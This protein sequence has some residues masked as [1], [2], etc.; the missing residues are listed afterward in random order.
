MKYDHSIGWYT[1]G[2]AKYHKDT[3]E[4][5]DGVDS[6]LAIL[7][8]RCLVNGIDSIVDFNSAGIPYIRGQKHIDLHTIFGKPMVQ[9]TIF[10]NAYRTLKLDEVS[11]AVL[12]DSSIEAREGGKYK[13]LTGKDIESLPVKEQR[14]V[15]RDAKLVMQLLKHNNEEILNAMKSISEL[16]RL[17]FERV[18]RTGIYAWWAAIFDNMIANGECQAPAVSL[19]DRNEKKSEL[20]YVEEIVL[21]PQKGLYHNLLVVDIASLYPTM[22]ILHNI[23]FAQ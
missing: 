22:A 13:A 19:F 12:G 17:D 14:Y 16:T 9:T 18:C 8:N 10:K 1:T 11:R 2:V 5:L 3:Q 7:H 15:L 6:D 21:Q 23:S 20:Q 4:Y